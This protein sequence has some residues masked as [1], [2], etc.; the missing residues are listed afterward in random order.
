MDLLVLQL[1]RLS[2]K[3]VGFSQEGLPRLERREEG[4]IILDIRFRD[5]SISKSISS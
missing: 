4:V 3:I 5:S 2:L 1:L